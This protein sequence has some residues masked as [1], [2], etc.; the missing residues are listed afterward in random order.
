M[1]KIPIN[2][3]LSLSQ[4]IPNVDGRFGPYTSVAEAN[5]YLGPAV[6]PT[7]EYD[8]VISAGMLFGVYEDDGSVTICMWTKDHATV[9]DFKRISHAQVIQFNG[10]VTG[11]VSINQSS[12]ATAKT[13]SDIKYLEQNKKFG[14]LQGSSYITNW[15]N[16]YV[17]ADSSQ[18]PYQDVLYL[19]IATNALYY[20]TGT[21]LVALTAG[22]QGSLVTSVNGQT[23]AVTITI[24]TKLSDLTND[25]GFITNAGVTS[26]NGQTGAVTY[27]P[28][29]TSVNNKTGAVV[30]DKTDVGL[31]NVDN[32]PD[33]N[34]QVYSAV[35]DGSGNPIDETY[36]TKTH[37]TAQHSLLQSNIDSLANVAANLTGLEGTNFGGFSLAVDAATAVSNIPTVFTQNGCT[38]G[39]PYW[40][41]AGPDMSS[42]VAYRYIGSGT[43]AAISATE[44][45]FT[46]FSRL[47]EQVKDFKGTI[48]TLSALDDLHNVADIGVYHVKVSQ[49]SG[50][51]IVEKYNDGLNTT[52]T[53]QLIASGTPVNQGGSYTIERGQTLARRLYSNSAWTSWTDPIAELQANVAALGPK[54]DQLGVWVESGEFIHAF[55]DADD[56]VL[57]GIRP[58]G[59]IYWAIGVPKPVKDYIEASIPDISGLQQ[60]IAGKVDKVEGKGLSTNDY[61][62][63]AKGMV[64]MN[65]LSE[66]PVFVHLVLDANKAILF[67]IE[68]NGNVHF[69]CGV[70]SQ[71][72]DAINEA[73]SR[74]SP[75]GL[76][77]VL[78]FLG[79][80][81]GGTTTL[82]TIIEGLQSNIMTDEQK[83]KVTQIDVLPSFYHTN[84]YIE[85]KIADI[86]EQWMQSGANADIF[87]FFTDAHYYNKAGH[88]GE[89]LEYIA[90]NS[91]VKKVVFGG[92]VGTVE[93][94]LE[95][96]MLYEEVNT[97]NLIVSKVSRSARFFPVRGNHDYY[98]RNTTAY[99]KTTLR[100]PYAATYNSILNQCNEPRIVL[101]ENDIAPYYYFDEKFSK[102]RY[103]VLDMFYK[104]TGV[105][106]GSYQIP[107]V[108]NALL[109]TPAGY[110]I[111]IVGHTS[112]QSGMMHD[113]AE[114]TSLQPLRDLVHAFQTNGTLSYDGVTY[115]FS[116]AVAKI[117]MWVSG[118]SHEDMQNYVDNVLFVCTP[119][120]SRYTNILY[121]AMAT[122]HEYPRR[123]AD[124]INEDCVD[125]VI[126]DKSNGIVYTKR[127]GSGFDRYF[128]L[129]KNTLAV[130]STL[131]LTSRFDSVATWLIHD[132]EG[133]TYN[134]SAASGTE[135]WTFTTNVSTI[136]NGVV[137]GVSAGECYAIAIASNGDKEFFYIKVN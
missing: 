102:T 47:S 12:G 109:T 104:S 78:D 50:L 79:S 16:R 25:V 54:I 76:Q 59:E 84:D 114:Y 15:V 119:C 108:A 101:N 121:S 40:F 107:F 72:Q 120:S 131:T 132:S 4:N 134:S 93:Q 58:N 52:I 49:F 55:V 26:F 82:Q 42:L 118:H 106:F 113:T 74:I 7:D 2:G 65:E 66:D 127:I 128:N 71:I 62:D 35:H 87:A 137:T 135:R 61:T 70:P 69:G 122:Y 1:P 41:L 95:T 103:V 45:D 110:T 48:T 81:V 100:Y 11:I 13:A 44:Y 3:P 38:V 94:A 37:A 130:G 111:T 98:S 19:N 116:S 99:G 73:V 75:S 133:A 21:A 6:N 112:I 85:N 17:W 30:L 80:Y 24:P 39:Q 129:T 88:T 124:T 18:N 10:I 34:K 46:D 105:A 9:N 43:P 22:S 83:Y 67:G 125:V 14:Y 8:D 91:H 90:Q 29:V 97:H 57:F 28:P 136:A 27:T 92:D 86:N 56:K 32:T 33:A 68:K 96:P 31:G 36:E 115:D 60:T 20:Y 123:T 89:L 63:D 64:E 51:L 126:A 53:Q 5:E 23:G 77:G 117:L